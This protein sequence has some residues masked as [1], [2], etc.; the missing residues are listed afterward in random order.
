M[1]GSHN[2]FTQNGPIV[3]NDRLCVN[4]RGAKKTNADPVNLTA[5]E[6]ILVGLTPVFMF[7]DNLIQVGSKS[8]FN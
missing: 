1:Y 7:R 4:E 3:K 8:Q 6:E 5:C 2:S